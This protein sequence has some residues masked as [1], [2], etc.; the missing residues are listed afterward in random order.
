MFHIQDTWFGSIGHIVLL[1][2]DDTWARTHKLSFWY[3]WILKWTHLHHPFIV[4]CT[5]IENPMC[6]RTPIANSHNFDFSIII[7]MRWSSSTTVIQQPYCYVELEVPILNTCHLRQI[8]R[9][10]LF[11]LHQVQI[12]IQSEDLI[13]NNITYNLK[14]PYNL[15]FKCVYLSCL[16]FYLHPITHPSNI[17]VWLR[18]VTKFFEEIK[19]G[20][21]L[22]HYGP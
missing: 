8:L 9:I 21:P 18:K 1:H 3:I 12:V 20:A 4:I 14:N 10:D 17:G 7:A 16:F 15:I 11:T 13:L 5:L 19:T 22:E 2:T 6:I